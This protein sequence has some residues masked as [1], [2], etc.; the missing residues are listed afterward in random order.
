VIP[1]QTGFSAALDGVIE[2]F[3]LRPEIPLQGGEV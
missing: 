1:P 2:V 3:F